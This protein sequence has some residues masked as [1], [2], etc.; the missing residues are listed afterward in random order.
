[1]LNVF[2]VDLEDWYQGLE[3]DIE[4]WERFAPRIEHGLEPLLSLLEESGTR[5]TFF[6][7]GH[8]AER[9]PELI[10]RVAA[11]GHEIACHGHAHRLVY[12]QTPAA[13][14]RDL[15]RSRDALEDIVGRPVRGYRAPFFSVTTEALWA[16][17]VLAEEGFRY[18]SSVFPVANYRYGMPGARRDAHWLRTPGGASLFEIP[19]STLALG[20]NVPVCG[21][22][23]FRLY[24]Y[25]LSRALIARLNARGEP[26][27]FY[28]HPWEY[29]PG[30]PRVPMPRRLARLTHYHRLGSTL[31]KTRR[32]LG[33]FAFSSVERVF[34]GPLDGA[35]G[36]LDG[37]RPAR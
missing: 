18:D 15:R 2:S 7:L 28:V 23:Y 1:M 12:R 5:A 26:L 14:R 13:F 29:D 30:H 36:V 3:I 34:A 31:G 8:Q 33:D 25:A 27:V 4:D 21:G 17:D 10:R 9:T 20:V 37:G 24:P 11:G 19:P 35:V 6:V 16:L 22:A 32:L